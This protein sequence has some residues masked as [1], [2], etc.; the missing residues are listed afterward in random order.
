MVTCILFSPL[1]GWRDR[2]SYIFIIVGMILV[3][4]FCLCLC[5]CI[6][7]F[8]IFAFADFVIGLWAAE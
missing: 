5:V 1:N 7:S 2:I 4:L 6:V 3:A 8:S